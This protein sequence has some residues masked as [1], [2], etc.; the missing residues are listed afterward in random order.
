MSTLVR[1]IDEVQ[2]NDSDYEKASRDLGVR[3]LSISKT[4]RKVAGGSLG[5]VGTTAGRIAASHLPR[6]FEDEKIG[7]E[8]ILKDLQGKWKDSFKFDYVMADNSATL[9]FDHC[10]VYSILTSHGEKVGGDLC[11]L[12]HAYIQGILVEV[13]Q[14]KFQMKVETMGEKCVLKVRPLPKFDD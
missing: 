4:L 2:V 13:V 5:A 14:D 6:M 12:F 10:P 7:F 3:L 11:S 8:D 9:T 1:N